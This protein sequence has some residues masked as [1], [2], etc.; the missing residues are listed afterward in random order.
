MKFSEY[1]KKAVA[2]ENIDKKAC[3]DR[4]IECNNDILFR[5]LT[6]IQT[7]DNH[8]KY[9]FYGT[10]KEKLKPSN[11]TRY[12]QHSDSTVCEDI[13]SLHGVYGLLTETEELMSAILNKDPVNIAEEIGDLMWYIAVLCDQHGVDLEQALDT[14]IKKLTS[15][16]G[17]K[18]SQEKAENR[19]LNRERDILSFNHLP[20]EDK[21]SECSGVLGVSQ[22]HL[23]DQLG[24]FEDPRLTVKINEL[25]HL[26]GHM[27]KTCEWGN[28]QIR[29][30]IL[31]TKVDEQGRDILTYIREV[32]GFEKL[33]Q[34][35]PMRYTEDSDVEH[36]SHY[37]QSD[38]EPI[39]AIEAWNLPFHLGNV[40]K[41]IARH[42]HKGNSIKD[43]KKARWY[44]DRYIS[45]VD[46]G[47]ENG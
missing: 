31:S 46:E 29:D 3:Q 42:E 6:H 35:I 43:L 18:F 14:N 27:K 28:T 5:T 32:G 8:K 34:V 33:F 47:E 15:R 16:Y 30:F 13:R 24:G 2:F 20:C 12:Y 40:I 25:Y 9:V 41:Y 10:E 7:L 21:I 45:L 44:L 39:D 22:I 17:N 19:D 11:Y 4:Y 38:I 37:T 26:I 36:P 23:L 1:I